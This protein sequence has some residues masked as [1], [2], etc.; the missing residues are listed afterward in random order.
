ME[1]RTQNG[2]QW[3]G[4]EWNAQQLFIWVTNFLTPKIFLF[5][6]NT[7]L[8]PQKHFSDPQTNFTIK[9]I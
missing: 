1:H 9:I 3:I 6:P 2:I 4:L 7:V 8:G 5:N